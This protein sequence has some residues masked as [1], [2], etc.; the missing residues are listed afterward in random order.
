MK[1]PA[2]GLLSLQSTRRDHSATLPLP[3]QAIQQR[4]EGSGTHPDTPA[5]GWTSS[6][7]M[8][9]EPGRAWEGCLDGKGRGWVPLRLVSPWGQVERRGS[10]ACL[11]SPAPPALSPLPAPGGAPHHCSLPILTQVPVRS[12]IL[13]QCHLPF[14]RAEFVTQSP[15]PARHGPHLPNPDTLHLSRRRGG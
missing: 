9:L 12:P 13:N 11:L 8:G 6:P 15:E 3:S 14:S 2:S 10:P 5:S 4:T 7:K 1:P